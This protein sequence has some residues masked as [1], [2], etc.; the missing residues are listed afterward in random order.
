[1]GTDDE[2]ENDSEFSYECGAT[3]ENIHSSLDE[4][5]YDGASMTL[6]EFVV[7]IGV[8]KSSSRQTD[9]QIANILEFF[10]LVLPKNNKC[11]QSLYKFKKYVRGIDETILKKHYF[12]SEC[13][14]LA[15]NTDSNIDDDELLE[16]ETQSISQ[17]Q[18]ERTLR[19]V[20]LAKKEQ[21]NSMPGSESGGFFETRLA[22]IDP[23]G[24]D[25]PLI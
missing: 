23:W 10:S 3:E 11:P 24:R 21:C 17:T 7:C 15:P 2:F 22:K 16:D 5:L 1:M 8:L 14:N 13:V 12:C 6:R 18:R 20:Q 19:R 9:T 4:E 25:R